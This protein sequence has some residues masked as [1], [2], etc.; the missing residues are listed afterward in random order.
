MDELTETMTTR[1]DVNEYAK[2]KRAETVEDKTPFNDSAKELMT[3]EEYG[4]YVKKFSTTT[5]FELK[6]TSTLTTQEKISI[7]M[8]NFEEFLKEKNIKYG[9]SALK[10]LNIFSKL[11][12]TNS[13]LVRLDD[14]LSRIMNN[15]KLQKNDVADMFGY[16]ALLLIDNNW[17][18]FGEMVD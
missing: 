17:L 3:V 14:K 4:E 8:T 16:L 13:I 6:D 9:D 12:A 11:D 15:P 2:K 1:I 18:E 10:P 5:V 7:L